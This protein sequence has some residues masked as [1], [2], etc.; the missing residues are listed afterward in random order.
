MKRREF[1]TLLG[2]AAT[3]TLPVRAQQL[4]KLPRIGVLFHAGRPEEEGPYFTGIIEGFSALG[5]VDGRNISFEHRFPNEIPARFRSMAAELVSKVDVL[6]AVGDRAAVFAKEASSTVPVVFV[7]VPD[8]IGSK[9]IESFAKPGGNVTGLSNYSSDL[10]GRRL[11][12]LKEIIPGL[13]R[14]AQLVNPTAPIAARNIEWTEAAAVKLGLTVQTF[15][16]RSLDELASAFDAMV[17]AGMQAVILS[18][19]EGL[20]MQGRDVIP[21]LAI[22]RRLALCTFSRETFEPGALMSYGTNQIANVRG[23]A[24]YVDKILKGGKPS[25]LPVEGPTRFEF[26]INLKIAKTLGLEVPAYLQQIADQVIG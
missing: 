24:T 22:E 18:A 13:S 9:L 5:Y 21:K 20:P 16:A 17:K 19:A 7:I 26:L 10:I 2:S 6:I 8:P 14:V 11:Q 3:W 4:A 12:M 23:A 25:E 1:I 15:A